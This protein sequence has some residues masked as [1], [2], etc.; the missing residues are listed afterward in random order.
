MSIRNYAALIDL[1][2]HHVPSEVEALCDELRADDNES[3]I[4]LRDGDRFVARLIQV[5]LNAQAA[6][7]LGPGNDFQIRNAEHL[8][9]AGNGA[10]LALLQENAVYLIA[11]GTGNLGLAVA[12]WMI[13]KGA[14]HLILVARAP[15]SIEAQSAI[16]RMRSVGAEVS[17]IPGDIASA[18]D[19]SKIFAWIDNSTL[20]LRGIVHAAGIVDDGTLEHLTLA[21]MRAVMA[22]KVSGAWELHLQTESRK[23]DFFVLFSSA[24]S[25]LGSPGVGNYAAANAFLDGLAH[26]RHSRGLPAISINWGP[27]AGSVQAARYRAA[28]GHEFYSASTIL[29]QEALGLLD[30][31]LCTNFPQVGILPFDW[32]NGVKWAHQRISHRCLLN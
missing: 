31:L 32:C 23:L 24:T 4:A 28:R 10:G 27:W 2:G 1:G 21:R 18:E 16:E 25:L 11:G 15:P 3:Q 13:G 8:G 17:T 12:E 22:A 5:S 29:P 20:P 30:K 14:R 26:H 9:R 6:S 7:S 19:V